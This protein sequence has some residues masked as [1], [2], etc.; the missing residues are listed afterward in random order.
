MVSKAKCAD[1]LAEKVPISKDHNPNSFLFATPGFK[2]YIFF[3]ILV[4]VAVG[5]MLNPAKKFHF[6]HI[7]NAMISF[8][9]LHWSKG[10]ENPQ[11]DGT[12]DHNTY[13]EQI[14][15][16]R[17]WTVS[18]KFCLI[19]PI[20]LCWVACVEGLWEKNIVL[21]HCTLLFVLELVPKF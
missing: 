17:Q 4:G 2:R 8:Y 20:F 18:R 21:L 3:I 5:H 15:N 12:Y 13:W 10:T 7:A 9:L 19:Y 1:S 16:G 6:V 14:D 11:S